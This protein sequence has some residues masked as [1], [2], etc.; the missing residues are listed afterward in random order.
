MKSRDRPDT[1]LYPFHS[2]FIDDQS[3]TSFV[4]GIRTLAHATEPVG[5]FI[6][7][8]SLFRVTLNDIMEL[9]RIVRQTIALRF[10]RLK[11]S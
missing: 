8:N 6:N 10:L 11:F 3:E 2:Q 7:L 5:I 9:K 1:F 4:S